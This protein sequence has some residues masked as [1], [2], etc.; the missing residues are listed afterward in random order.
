MCTAFVLRVK[1]GCDKP[2]QRPAAPQYKAPTVF[3][4][5]RRAALKTVFNLNSEECVWPVG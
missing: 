3:H 5:L 2:T 4:L 1:E